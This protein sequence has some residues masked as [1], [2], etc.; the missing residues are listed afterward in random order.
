MKFT[1][2]TDVK[3]DLD[4]AFGAFADFDAFER[5]ALR[6][7]AKISRTDDL[8]EPGP[9]MMWDVALEFR[10]KTRKI[11]VELVDYDPG[12]CLD[13]EA[14]ADGFDAT[15]EVDLESLPDQ[16]TRATISFD[17]RARTLA[18]RL[19]LQ[20]ARLTKGSLNKRFRSRVQRIGKE[21]DARIKTT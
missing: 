16:K 18:A 19:A 17:V 3:A 1:G 10:G 4:A 12:N 9:G 7:G 8:T 21:I 20:T 14:S 11:G 6:S 2:K 13:F 5:Q 15:I